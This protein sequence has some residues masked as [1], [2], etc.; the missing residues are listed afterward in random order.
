MLDFCLLLI[1]LGALLAEALPQ[2]AFLK[3]L[4]ALRVLRP[5]RLLSR[6]A[7]MKM[8]LASLAEAFPAV[9]NVIGVLLAM[10]VR[11]TDCH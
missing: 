7:G 9:A 2:L 4:R 8:V 6:N 11:A 3:S 5:L 10:Q 1:S